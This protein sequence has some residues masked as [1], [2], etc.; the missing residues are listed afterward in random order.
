MIKLPWPGDR[1]VNFVVFKSS[2]HL[3]LSV[4]HS[5]VEA[6]SLHTLP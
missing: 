2:C 5:K 3:L 4:N 1:E 6:I